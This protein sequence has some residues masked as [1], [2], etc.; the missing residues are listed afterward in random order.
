MSS[1]QSG[2]LAR[3]FT[4]HGKKGVVPN[5]PVRQ[6]GQVTR[7]AQNSGECLQ[8]TETKTKTKKTFSFHLSSSRRLLGEFTNLVLSI[9][10][11]VAW[12]I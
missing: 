10:T 9:F 12:Q 5:F 1:A 8:K 3:S 6:Q 11:N 2:P 4:W 7:E